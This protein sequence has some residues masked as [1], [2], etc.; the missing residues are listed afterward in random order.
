MT[1]WVQRPA[2]IFALF[3][4]FLGFAV[5]AFMPQIFHDGDTWWHLAAGGWMLDHRAVLAR[6]VF[7]FT[8]MGK[9]WDAQEWL[10]EVLMALAFYGLGWNGLHLLFGF[11]L[12]ATAAI[13]AGGVRARIP[14]LPAMLISL[15]GL[16]CL[17]GSVLARPH[18]LA[19]PLLALWTWELLR[20]RDERR[21][22]GW[23]LV[24]VMLLQYA[25]LNR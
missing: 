3:A 20:A 6:D 18:L 11:S 16:A 22:P 14:A 24:A 5:A 19:L 10:S 4:G 2:L 17:S 9:P 12:A 1:P 23:W 15:V 8:F 21:A 7:S 13:V 25:A